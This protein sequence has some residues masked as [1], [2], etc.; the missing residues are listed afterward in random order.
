MRVL[1][2]LPRETVSW[3]QAVISTP[4]CL[5]EPSHLCG[6]QEV[7]T[8]NSSPT[9]AEGP[10]QTSTEMQEH[11]GVVTVYHLLLLLLCKTKVLREVSC[12][13]ALGLSSLYQHLVKTNMKEK[14]DNRR[15]TVI[16]FLWA[17]APRC[18]VT[19][20]GSVHYRL[21]DEKT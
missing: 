15:T 3:D 21:R 18:S 13:V 17:Q 5:A 14:G 11:R 8:F 4:A 16:L 20:Y 2:S 19:L 7:E 9:T 1:R 12:S 10:I 6:V